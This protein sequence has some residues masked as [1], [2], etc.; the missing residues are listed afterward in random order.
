MTTGLKAGAEEIVTLKVLKN[1]NAV[2]NI[3]EV[4]QLSSCAE[5]NFLRRVNKHMGRGFFYIGGNRQGGN[6]SFSRKKKGD[7]SFE[8]SEIRNYVF[9]F[10][11]MNTDRFSVL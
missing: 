11:K 7:R 1:E 3:T 4:P 6:A 9:D 10:C 2:K 8:I 5:F